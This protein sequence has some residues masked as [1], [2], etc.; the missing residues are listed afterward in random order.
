MYTF[1]FCPLWQKWSGDGMIL[2]LCYYKFAII[3]TWNQADEISH[4]LASYHNT[5]W[6]IIC[7]LFCGNKSHSSCAP[8]QPC[9]AR[10]KPVCIF[11]GVP[12]YS[13]SVHVYSAG[14]L[15]LIMAFHEWGWN[16]D[17]E[18][19]RRESELG[20]CS[21]SSKLTF[22]T[23]EDTIR[24]HNNWINSYINSIKS[25][26]ATCMYMNLMS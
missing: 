14:S 10:C 4:K 26:A 23:W 8:G 3:N 7:C 12:A 1:F 24:A 22:C 15:M 18:S 21:K 20:R 13:T 5:S 25:E 17:G 16:D 11:P 2:S 19:S 6:L 9:P